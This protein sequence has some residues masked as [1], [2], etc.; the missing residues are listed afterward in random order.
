[1]QDFN[2]VADSMHKLSRSSSCPTP[3]NSC[4]VY[5]Q[6]RSSEHKSHPANLGTATLQADRGT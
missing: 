1:M 5:N 6:H 2:N 3:R 4:T